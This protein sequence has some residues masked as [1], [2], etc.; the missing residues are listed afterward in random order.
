MDIEEVVAEVCR[1]P[2]LAKIGKIVAL[3]DER[4]LDRICEEES[5]KL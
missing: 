4:T 2:T 1:K 3:L 5:M